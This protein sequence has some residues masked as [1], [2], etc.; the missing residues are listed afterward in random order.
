LRA[1]ERLFAR[2]PELCGPAEP[3]ARLH[4]DLWGGNLHVDE[5]SAYAESHP[6]APGHAERVPL[7]QLYPLLVHVNLFGESYLR[8]VERALA[9]Y[10]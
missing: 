10:V 3:P 2:L 1:F 4:G 8:S 7:Y 9:E 6:L 5:T